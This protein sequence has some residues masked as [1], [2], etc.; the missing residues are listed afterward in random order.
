MAAAPAPDEMGDFP[1]STEK[2][3]DIEPARNVDIFGVATEIRC[4]MPLLF[5]EHP[6]KRKE[7][8]ED[9]DLRLRGLLV[10]SPHCTSAMLE[11][12]TWRPTVFS[13]LASRYG[14]DAKRMASCLQMLTGLNQGDYSIEQSFE[15]AIDELVDD[16]DKFRSDVRKEL[17]RHISDQKAKEKQ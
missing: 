17:A 12:S 11:L 5:A 4:V 8:N 10:D 14:Y 2:P 1:F 15:K 13:R 3:K 7:S 6:Q 16:P 9:Y